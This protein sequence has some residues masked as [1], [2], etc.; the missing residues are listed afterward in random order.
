MACAVA[1]H[2]RTGIGHVMAE[3]FLGARDLYEICNPSM[4]AM[5]DAMASAPGCIG[6]RQAGAGFGGCMIALVDHH[7]VEA[8]SEAVAHQ[9]QSSSQ[10]APAVFPVQAADGAAV[11]DLGL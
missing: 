1:A 3:S 10:I 8:F 2:D 7:S 4:L 11:I 5:F 9:Y 6:C